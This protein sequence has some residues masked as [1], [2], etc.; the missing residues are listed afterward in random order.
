MY[1]GKDYG[2]VKILL[3]GVDGWKKA[4]YPLV[5]AA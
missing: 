1:A 4:G 3:G 5:R 2:N